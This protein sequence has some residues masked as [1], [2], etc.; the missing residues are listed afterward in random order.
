MCRR[1]LVVENFG[2]CAVCE[3]VQLAVGSYALRP[4]GPASGNAAF[5]TLEISLDRWL[6]FADQPG[7]G[8]QGSFYRSVEKLTFP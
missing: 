3:F 4:L 6:Q 7:V 5:R 1:E 8:R 2:E